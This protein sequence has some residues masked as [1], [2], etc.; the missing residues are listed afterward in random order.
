L[1]QDV[2]VV[3]QVNARKLPLRDIV[4]ASLMKEGAVLWA[5]ELQVHS[6][7]AAVCWCWY[8]YQ[9]DS[10]AHACEEA[11]SMLSACDG[12]QPFKFWS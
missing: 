4:L 1:L 5:P 9:Q 6:Q 11:E 8:M 3:D 2:D 12:A 10:K 7:V